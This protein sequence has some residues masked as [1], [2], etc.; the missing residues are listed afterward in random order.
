M[1]NDWDTVLE[2][3]QSASKPISIAFPGDGEINIPK[4]QF[5]F[6]IL[7]PLGTSTDILLS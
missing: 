2:L 6:L 5:M 4:L 3:M 7:D 1:K